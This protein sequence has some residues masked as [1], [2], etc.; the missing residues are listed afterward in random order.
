[1]NENSIFRLKIQYKTENQVSGDIEKVKLEIFA[2]CVN[3]TD[4]ES[5][6]Y[7]LIDQYDLNKYEPC[8]YDIMRTKFEAGAI[9]GRSPLCPDEGSSICGLV[10][11]YFAEESEGL[12]AVE[13]IVFG[14]KEAKE[15]DLKRTFYIPATNVADAMEAAGQILNY[16][17]H[18]LKDCLIPSAKLDNAAYVYLRRK[19]SSI[20]YELANVIFK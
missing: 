18:S 20:A 2:Q 1:M 17:G 12:Y 5:V 15:K 16:E 4:A 9:Y 10:Q 19:T 3:Y 8:V 7:G 13:T 6:V 14:D 11:H